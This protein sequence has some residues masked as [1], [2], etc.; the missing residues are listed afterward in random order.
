MTMISLSKELTIWIILVIPIFLILIIK[1]GK[2]KKDY[3]K[4]GAD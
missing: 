3:T 1:L 4:K 2:I